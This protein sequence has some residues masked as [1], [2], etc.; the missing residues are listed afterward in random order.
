MD[1]KSSISYL[2]EL[3]RAN[4]GEP[5]ILFFLILPT[6]YILS[7][8]LSKNFEFSCS[9][10]TFF[11]DERVEA[12]TDY[13]NAVVSGKLLLEDFKILPHVTN[14]LVI[15]SVCQIHPV[16]TRHILQYYVKNNF[17]VSFGVDLKIR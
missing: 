2:Y 16:R 10:G 7:F 14:T 11:L 15:L 6:R 12:K 17:H 9:V 1:T 13:K 8:L 5:N 3:Y 4:Q